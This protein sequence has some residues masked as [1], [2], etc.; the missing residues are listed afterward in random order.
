M[1]IFG[2][3]KKST[4][5]ISIINCQ[6]ITTAMMIDSLTLHPSH[7]LDVLS[8]QKEKEILRMK[9]VNCKYEHDSKFC[10]NCGEISVVPKITFS[11]IFN[12]GFS[13]IT[14]MD[15]GFLFNVKNLFLNP[16]KTVNEYL[17]GKRKHIYNPISFLIISITIYLIADSLI[18]VE[19]ESNIITSKVY[20]VGYEAGK[21]IKLYSK[22]FWILSLVWLSISTRLIFKKFNYAEHLA[23]SSFV[24]G[25]ATLLGLISFLFFKT[26]LLFN[27]LVYISIIWITYEIFKSKKKNLE[28]FLMSVVSTFL[29]FIQLVIILV[30][31]GIIRS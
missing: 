28:I 15:K 1:E 4:K 8:K 14:N 16:N 10:P 30:L 21:F 29:F 13:T 9:C 17:N 20:S 26:I 19:S 22:Y 24:I 6:A 31:I 5:L 18:V 27:P 12:S 3:M 2:F 25:Q 7:S 23:I 11:S